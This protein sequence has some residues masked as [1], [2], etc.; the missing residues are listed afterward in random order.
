MDHITGRLNAAGN[1]TGA[2]NPVYGSGA[3]A[4]S[5]LEDVIISNVQNSQII[6]YHA[7]LQKWVNVDPG[8]VLPFKDK[9]LLMSKFLDIYQVTAVLI[10]DDLS[11]KIIDIHF[12]YP[13]VQLE[14]I[15]ITFREM[16]ELGPAYDIS[17]GASYPNDVNDMKCLF[18]YRDKRS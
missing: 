5:E 17:I 16:T 6:Q 8:N 3:S 12:N 4:L 7:G 14:Y 13:M 15:S 10:G 9:E 1:I 2:L 18:S 11:N